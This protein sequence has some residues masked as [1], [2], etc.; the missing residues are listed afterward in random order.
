MQLDEYQEKLKLSYENNFISENIRELIELFCDLANL[1]TISYFKYD[2]EYNDFFHKFD[3]SSDNSNTNKTKKNYKIILK[4][5]KIVYGYLLINQRIKSNPILKKMLN[6][7]IKYLK[8][9]KEIQKKILGNELPFSIY[10]FH[11]E[12]LELFAENLKSGLEGLF[13]VD[14]TQDTSIEKYFDTLKSKE[15]KHII[16]FLINDEKIILEV[17]EKIKVLNE[18]IIVIGP[19][20]HHISMYCGRIGIE[21]YVSINEFKA[22]NVKNIILN[23]KNTLFNKNKFG[24]K[25]IA[26]GGISGG[27]GST[28]IAMNMADLISSNLPNKNILYIDLS[29]TK[30]ISNL[31]LENNPLPQK[32]II[33]LI[34]SNEFNLENNLENGLIKKRENF[35]CITGIQ[36]HID[37]EFLEKDVFIEKLL[38]YIS[39]SSNYF[40]FIIIDTGTANASNLKSTIYDI[41]NEF[42][43]I[44]EMTLPHI[45]KLKTFYSLMKRAGLK[46][47]ISFIVN[48]YD[49]QNAISVTDVTSILN[50][51]SEDK[52]Q[53]DSF[54]IP[55]DYNVL[56]KCWNYCELASKNYPDSLFIKKLDAILQEKNFYKNEQKKENKKSIFSSFFAK[57]KS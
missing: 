24:N 33:D 19:N 29:T 15:T 37:K 8:R 31:F 36:K 22:E 46:D 28:T 9:E 7:I 55:N 18:L 54:K 5:G 13:N 43:L 49:S 38:D 50:M 12:E 21:D 52:M 45:S 4:D 14:V 35:Y 25:I 27:I 26:I 1:E 40:N 11:D 56:G 16:I 39:T 51:N 44:T 42:W 3:I 30:A 47:K 23:K 20:N 10:L 41:V 57:D 32:S 17:E 2:Y 48:R 53:F 6:K 34:N